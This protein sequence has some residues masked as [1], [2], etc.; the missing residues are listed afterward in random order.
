M[1]ILFFFFFFNNNKLSMVLST[2]LS[3][4]D[5][6]LFVILTKIE[7]EARLIK[8]ESYSELLRFIIRHILK[9]VHN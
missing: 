7:Y 4:E 1:N 9:Q 8:E 5:Y 2:K 3:I 6:F